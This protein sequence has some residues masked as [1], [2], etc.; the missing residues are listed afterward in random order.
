MFYIFLRN[1]LSYIRLSIMRRAAPTAQ[2]V[3]LFFYTDFN[4]WQQSS[5]PPLHS[6]VCR[7]RL[8]VRT[9]LLCMKGSCR[10][11]R[12]YGVGQGRGSKGERDCT[13]SAA[14]ISREAGFR[15]S[16]GRHA[17]LY[18]HKCIHSLM[19]TCM[20]TYSFLDIQIHT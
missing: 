18:T 17:Y 7:A 19:H 9:Y 10:A 4:L 3:F 20:N 8:S 1:D 12:R 5:S 2:Y 13:Q 15:V 16:I 11:G 6:G 14:R